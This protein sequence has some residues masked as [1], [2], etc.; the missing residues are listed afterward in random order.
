MITYK[1]LLDDYKKNSNFK[2][3]FYHDQAECSNKIKKAHSVQ[4][5]RI[6]SQLESPVN[7]NNLI[8]SLNEFEDED[9]KTKMLIPFGKNKASIFTGFCD[10]HDSKLFSPVENVPFK[11]TSEQL[12]LLTYRAFAHGLH[13][14]LETYNYYI[15]KGE[16]IKY[17]PPNY[18]HEHIK[19]TRFRIE[20]SLKYKKILNSQ[21][22]QK[23]FNSI[24]Y[25]YRI[26]KPFVPLACSSILSPLYT[27]KNISLNPREEYSY[28]VL[29][30]IP[31]TTQTFVCISQFAEDYKGKVFF[32]EFKTLTDT[33]FEIAIS[34][35]LIYCTTNTFFSPLLWDKF[36]YEEK[37][38]L[39]SEIDFCIKEGDKIDKFFLSQ[40]NFF[41][42]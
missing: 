10:F 26:I 7:G 38:Q 29:N 33:E 15:S 2:Y 27:F 42:H 21:I 19:L 25:H 32:E 9:F 20:K 39:Y 13:Q 40:I 30:I 41:K 28:L 31:D 17:F 16:F 24:S 36:T 5:N 35:L 11:G 12:F 37:Q 3:C 22:K 1:L 14:L 6:L 18:L 4:K 8:Y 34:S 23:D